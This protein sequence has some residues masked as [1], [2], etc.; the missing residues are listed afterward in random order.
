[1]KIHMIIFIGWLMFCF[2]VCLWASIYFIINFHVN[3]FDVDKFTIFIKWS[4]MIFIASA[5]IACII[6]FLNADKL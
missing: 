3:M 2:F 1:M 4:W 5:I 6:I